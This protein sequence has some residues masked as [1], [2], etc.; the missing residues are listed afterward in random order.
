[1]DSSLP[2]A[3]FL[4]IHSDLF[5]RLQVKIYQNKM[6]FGKVALKTKKMVIFFF[7]PCV[8]SLTNK[9]TLWILLDCIHEPVV[10]EIVIVTCVVESL[11]LQVNQ[12]MEI[13]PT[14]TLQFDQP[15]ALWLFSN[16]LLTVRCT[17]HASAV[18][19]FALLSPTLEMTLTMWPLMYCT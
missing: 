1:M 17:V 15:A 13:P 19:R 14:R 12:E 5:I 7:A 3:A 11:L 2:S 8:L 9:N 6:W 4:Q 18:Y 10:L 16:A